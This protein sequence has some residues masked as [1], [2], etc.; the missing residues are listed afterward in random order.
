MTKYLSFLF[1]GLYMH[2]FCQNGTA[3]LYNEYKYKAEDCILNKD[4]SCAL[5]TYLEQDKQFEL[6]NSEL[7]NA[8]VSALICKD[9]TNIKYFTK[10]FLKRGASKLFIENKF[11]NFDYFSSQD[12]LKLKA[13]K[14]Q[15]SYNENMR[16]M[17][18]EMH[19]RDQ[20]DRADKKVMLSNDFQNLIS[21][22][23]MMGNYGFPG[24]ISL[25]IDV[26]EDTVSY[27]GDFKNIMVHLVKLEPWQFGVLLKDIYNK[28]GI[29]AAFFVYL[30]SF[31]STCDDSQLACFPNPPSSILMVENK[32]FT[33]NPEELERIDSNRKRFFLDSTY[34]QIRK[35]KFSKESPLP[36]ILHDGY[37]TYYYNAQKYTLDEFCKKLITDG[38]IE[39]T[40]NK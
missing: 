9:T 25:G 17:I 15:F 34:D 40:P 13:E 38:L 20:A 1:F 36:W 31:S 22:N 10:K 21:F 26:P 4:Y 7:Q 5:Y 37:A 32:I 35:I 24:E 14:Y 16:K 23:E 27:Y 33:C 11:K 39:Y 18:A 3:A 12:W 29:P 28:N 2:A 8:L 6:W 30:M 19:K